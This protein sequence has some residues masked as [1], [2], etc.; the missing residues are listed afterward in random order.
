MGNLESD[1]RVEAGGAT[2]IKSIYY[3]QSRYYVFAQLRR[4]SPPHFL[5]RAFMRGADPSFFIPLSKQKF[6][7]P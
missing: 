7:P 4:C 5:N 6:L 2:K 3:F 1:A